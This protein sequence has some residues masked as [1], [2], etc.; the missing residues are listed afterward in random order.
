MFLAASC[1][2]EVHMILSL[3]CQSAQSHKLTMTV[4]YSV[5]GKQQHSPFEAL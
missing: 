1:T 3:M 2:F 5:S 4:Y